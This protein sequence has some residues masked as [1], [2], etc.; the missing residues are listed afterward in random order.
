MTILVRFILLIICLNSGS[1]KTTT[2]RALY[3]SEYQTDRECGVRIITVF[4]YL[5]DVEAG[6]GTDFPD[7]DLTVMPKRGSALIWPSVL[8]SDPNKK[9]GRTDHQALPVEQG[10]KYGANACK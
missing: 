7:L 6:G 2:D 3:R 1:S 5:N 10:I 9:D 4:L 8:D